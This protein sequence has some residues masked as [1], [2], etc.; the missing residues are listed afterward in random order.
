[1]M[2]APFLSYKYPVHLVYHND[3]SSDYSTKIYPDVKDPNIDNLSLSQLFFA[4]S[5]ASDR[6][7]QCARP[8]I[9]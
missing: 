3:L 1:M 4:H 5:T 6:E 2:V 9:A 7:L 8:S